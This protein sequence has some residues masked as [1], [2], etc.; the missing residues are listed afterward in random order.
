MRSSASA[1]RKLS[2]SGDI[3]RSTKGWASVDLQ[4]RQLAPEALAGCTNSPS[5]ARLASY[6]V[7]VRVEAP[8]V[9]QAPDAPDAQVAIA[10]ELRLL[11]ADAP[12][13]VAQLDHAGSDRPARLEL[14]Q[15]A[16]DA[17]EVDAI[18]ARIGAGALR[19]LDDAARDR[20]LHQ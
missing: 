2:Q 8:F 12:E 14:G 19:V 6:P 15:C 3:P 7:E 18:A 20:L 11:E 16:R 9:E 10:F 5:P 4:K 1:A 17:A 13:R